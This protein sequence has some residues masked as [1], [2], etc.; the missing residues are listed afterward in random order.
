MHSK[1]SQITNSS[2]K[3][4]DALVDCMKQP[5]YPNSTFGTNNSKNLSL[6]RIVYISYSLTFSAKTLSHEKAK[7]KLDYLDIK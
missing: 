1:I 5:C 4:Q 2:N 6:F 7:I 3:R